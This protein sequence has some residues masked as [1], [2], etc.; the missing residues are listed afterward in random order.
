MTPLDGLVAVGV[1]GAA[2][3]VAAMA[4]FG[5]ALLAMPLLSIAIGPTSALAVVSLVSIVN[6]GATALTAR[7]E[8]ARDVLRRQVP[9]AFVGMPLGIVVLESV[10]GRGLQIAIAVTV[11][12]VAAAIG[13]QLRLPPL[14]ARGEV[15][16]GLTSGALATSTGASGP[17]LVFCL[18][19]RRL[20]APTVRATLASHFAVTGWVG[21]MLLALRGHIDGAH[22]IVALAALPVMLA[23]WRLGASSFT[24]ISQRRYESLVAW[25][26]LASAAAAF[27]R[28]V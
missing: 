7:A 2:S 26:L 8:V 10:S 13:L 6:S 14:G 20:P 17:P 24:R 25:L 22:V 1:L 11:A 3:I 19:S 12:I 27:V 28:A 23:A 18:Q 15:M 9:A 16:A 4:G 21:T 5:F